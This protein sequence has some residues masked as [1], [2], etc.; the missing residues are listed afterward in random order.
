MVAEGTDIMNFV[1]WHSE[2]IG[3][4]WQVLSRPYPDSLSWGMTRSIKEGKGLSSLACVVEVRNETRVD[5]SGDWA[6][7][8]VWPVLGARAD[9]MSKD[10]WAIQ[11]CI[12]GNGAFRF[13]RLASLV[14]DIGI[15]PEIWLARANS[16]AGRQ[17][18]RAFF[19][20][21]GWWYGTRLG[22]GLVD[23]VYLDLE[24][25]LGPVS[26]FCGVNQNVVYMW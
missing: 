7:F 13:L 21:Q 11:I 2:F 25:F 17:L 19:P 16:S 4:V 18:D 22:R 15:W 9:T 6:I 14:I 1:V 3:A 12:A 24:W 10:A 23:L 5:E 26:E 20:P 8:L